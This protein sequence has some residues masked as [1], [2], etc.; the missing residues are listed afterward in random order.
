MNISEKV[1]SEKFE[2]IVIGGGPSGMTLANLLG[3]Y[4]IKTLVLEQNKHTVLEPRAVSI[5]DE[6]LRTMQ[7]IGLHKEVVSFCALDYGS[8]YY[9]VDSK[10][11]A[12]IE[13]NASEYGYPRRNAFSQPDLE[14]TLRK[15]ATRYAH[16]DVRF[17][18]AVTHFTQD[19]NEVF[20]TVLAEGKIY[21]VRADYLA[22]ADG[23]RSFTRTSLKI[24][25]EGLTYSQK[26]LI[27]DIKDTKDTF[28]QTRVY[29]NTKRP[30]I[31]LPGPNG[32][33]R[34]EFMLLPGE[35]DEKVVE[36]QFVRELMGQYG[37]DRDAFIVRKQVYAFHARKSVQWKVGR[38]FLLGDAAHLTPPFA[39]Q[40]MN[41]GLR[42]S[43]NLAWKLAW[44]I[45]HGMP[46]HILDTYQE[47]RMPHSWQLIEMAE[48]LGRIMMPKTMLRATLIQGF[49]RLLSLYKP[50]RDY[51]TQM[52]YKPKPRFPSGWFV[53]DASDKN[54]PAGLMVAQPCLETHEREHVLLDDVLQRG[55]CLLAY[56]DCPGSAFEML[57]PYSA[58]YNNKIHRVCITPR[59][60]N[61]VAAQDTTVVRDYKDEAQKW[62]FNRSSSSI[63][64]LRPD[65]YIVAE[66]TP[67]NLAYMAE[68]LPSY[69]PS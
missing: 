44:V 51:V 28:R 58:I 46:K 68:T 34:F 55:F 30:G 37:P 66:I 19:D 10:P 17:G 67:K 9:G 54:S 56:S 27:I 62:I 52:R 33:R 65:R 59:T 21:E 40:G 15:G 18:H 31:N 26:W 41:S 7:A 48:M 29:C 22:A 49:L 53:K 4:G 14:A 16:V 20:I 64:L 69:V 35:T 36:E 23:G 43:A 42:D 2:V 45:K 1:S 12:K 39:G 61:P 8:V 47:E 32:T 3:K 60:W 24:P 5:D 25:L 57:K 13:P 38:I 6:S 50:A 11:F 63:F